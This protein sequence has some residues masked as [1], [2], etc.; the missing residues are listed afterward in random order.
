MAPAIIISDATIVLLKCIVCI[1]MKI[2]I[3][4][5]IGQNYL[6]RDMAIESGSKR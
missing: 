5:G 4:S 6:S 3:D 1:L 2:V